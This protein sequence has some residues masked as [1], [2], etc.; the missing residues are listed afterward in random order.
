[1]RKLAGLMLVSALSFGCAPANAQSSSIEGTW[2]GGGYAQLSSGQREKIRCRVRYTRET[3]DVFGVS[4]VCASPSL[5]VTQTGTISRVA[6][7]RFVGDLY[8]PEFDVSGRIRVVVSGS[9]Q[10]VTMSSSKGSGSLTL[11]R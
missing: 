5:K 4:A 6:A 8:N 11:S 10:S 1:M 2:S 3:A 9:Q 7:N